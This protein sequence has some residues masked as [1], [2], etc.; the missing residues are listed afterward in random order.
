MRKKILA[1]TLTS[2]AISGYAIAQTPKPDNS[3][4]AHHPAGSASGG[5]ASAYRM[6]SS[7]EAYE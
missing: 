2:M 5:P 1:L 6:T 4:S 3:H 7:P